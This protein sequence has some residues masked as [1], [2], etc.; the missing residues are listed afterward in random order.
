MWVQVP[1]RAPNPDFLKNLALEAHFLLPSVARSKGENVLAMRGSWGPFSFIIRASLG[2]KKVALV[3]AENLKL[4]PK[5][6]SFIIL[7][8]LILLLMI[9]RS[10]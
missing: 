6:C 1:P 2:D 7:L 3:S 5:W 9:N 10:L 8:E 4:V